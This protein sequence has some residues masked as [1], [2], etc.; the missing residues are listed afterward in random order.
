MNP[1]NKEVTEPSWLELDILFACLMS[2]YGSDFH[3][4]HNKMRERSCLRGD[5]RLVQHILNVG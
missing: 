2:R 3:T 4:T 5:L 1:R